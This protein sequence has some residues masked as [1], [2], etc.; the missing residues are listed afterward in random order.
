MA[1]PL[2][3]FEI[4]GPDAAGLAE[5]YRKVFGWD[6]QPGPF[7]GYFN[8][9]AEGAGVR[10]G[11]RLEGTPERVLYV[12]VPDLQAALDLVVKRGGKVVIPPT[13]IPNVVSFA[14]FEDP[15]GNRT[16]IML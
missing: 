1:F 8:I 14:M 2:A 13:H 10:G 4:A 12:K 9:A 16:G 7:P 3:Y 5:F 11:V 6:I 15:A